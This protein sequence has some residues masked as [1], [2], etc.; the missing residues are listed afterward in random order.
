M[1]M[2][3]VQSASDV[4]GTG[5]P[6]SASLMARI[7]H[8]TVGTDG[9]GEA[10]PGHNPSCSQKPGRRLATTFRAQCLRPRMTSVTSTVP[11]PLQSPRRDPEPASVLASAST[12]SVGSRPP[13]HTCNTL[14]RLAR[15]EPA[16]IFGVNRA[17]SRW[18]TQGAF[19]GT[20]QLCWRG[21]TML[22]LQPVSFLGQRAIAAHPR[23]SRGPAPTFLIGLR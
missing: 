17:G 5:A 3:V 21:I 16:R 7:R 9:A 6:L 12:R 1:K 15:S 20:R 14:R 18:R 11:S 2:A 19:A 22:T 23:I 13:P 8:T 10:G 4:D